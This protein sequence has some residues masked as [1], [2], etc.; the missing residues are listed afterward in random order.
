MAAGLGGIVRDVE[1]VGI[2]PHPTA[3]LWITVNG[4]QYTISLSLI[5]SHLTSE[6]YGSN[7]RQYGTPPMKD[8][9]SFQINNKINIIHFF[10]HNLDG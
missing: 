6:S 1:T 3:L 2:P 5:L 7:L 9:H 4:I 10:F 8:K